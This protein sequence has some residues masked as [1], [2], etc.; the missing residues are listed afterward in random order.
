MTRFLLAALAGTFT[1]AAASAPAQPA[2]AAVIVKIGN[3]T[4]GPQAL[5]VAAGTTVTWV[6]QDDI[7]H[8]VVSTDGGKSFR[9]KVLDTGDRFSFTFAR[10][11]SFGY[12]C[13]IH[14]HM[15]GK[16]VVKPR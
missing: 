2:P 15:V 7:P 6:N 16:V 12:F 9:S 5:T 8:T 10:P 11:G 14:P 1:F 3:F 13:S 4:F